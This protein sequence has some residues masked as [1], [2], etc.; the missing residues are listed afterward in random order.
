MLILEMVGAR[1]QNEVTTTDSSSKYFPDWLHDENI[2]QFCSVTCG[3]IEVVRK[4]VVIGLWPVAEP[5]GPVGAVPTP[6][7]SRFCL[8]SI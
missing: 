4:M 1:K 5:G 6:Q 3:N 8:I 2:N 7:H